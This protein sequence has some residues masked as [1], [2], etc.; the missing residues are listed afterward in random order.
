[1]RHQYSGMK[2]PHGVVAIRNHKVQILFPDHPQNFTTLQLQDRYGKI[3]YIV[4]LIVK[5]HKLNCKTLL[6]FDCYV[7]IFFVFYGMFVLKII[8]ISEHM[9]LIVPLFYYR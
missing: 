5:I 7:H 1:M 2:I 9:V 4:I 6:Y 3:Y 8:P